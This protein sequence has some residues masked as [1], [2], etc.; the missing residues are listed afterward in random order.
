MND[1]VILEARE[2]ALVDRVRP[3]S[4]KIWHLSDELFTEAVRTYIAGGSFAKIRERL[5]KAG[6]TESD[7]PSQAAW[8]KFWK[9]FKPFLRL[10]RRRAAA[11]R[12]NAVATEA[13][14]S[15]VDFD[16]AIF[17]LI[18][19]LTLELVDSDGADPKE[20][21]TLVGLLIKH[22]N[23]QLKERLV[24][25]A[26]QRVALAKRR[27][28]RMTPKVEKE[29]P[30]TPEERDRRI[31]KIFGLAEPDEPGAWRHPAFET[32]REQAQGSASSKVDEGADPHIDKG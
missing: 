32:D 27:E 15:P 29:T 5:A 4:S 30:M 8:V 17:D 10:A 18:R 24:K 19:Q 26:E 11:E 2:L 25:V 22:R 20:V 14:Q 6:V 28:K 16:E 7:L 23:H 13:R 31:R 21:S 12:A 3:R 1:S 9:T